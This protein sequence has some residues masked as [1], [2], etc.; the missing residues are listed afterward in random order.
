MKF[1]VAYF[2]FYDEAALYGYTTDEAVEVLSVS[3][4]DYDTVFL[5]RDKRTHGFAWV[6]EDNFWSEPKG[7]WK[8]T[9]T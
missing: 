3:R 5:I 8:Q 2:A 6:S 4:E 1:F 7:M 9:N